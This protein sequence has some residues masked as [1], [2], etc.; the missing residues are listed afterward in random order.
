MQNAIDLR[1]DTVTRPT[2]AM[3]QA[4]IDA[5]V[6]DDVYAEDPSINR[7]QAMTAE[8]SGKEAALFFPSGT[9]SNQASLAAH[10]GRCREVVMPEGAHVYEYEPAAMALVSS[11]IPRFVTA[12]LGIPSAADVEAVL[13]SNIHQAR[14]GLI[15]LENTHNQAGGT[16]IP[17]ENAQ[18]IG[19]VARKH[20]LPYH[21]DGARAWNAMIALEC[22]LEEVCQPFDSVSLCLSKGLAAPVGTV[23]VG[24][25]DFIREAHRYRKSLG[26][27]MRQ[28]GMV[29]AAGIVA[30]EQMIPRLSEDHSNAR[31][32]AGNL[33]DH[34]LLEIDMASVQSNMV[35][36][37]VANPKALAQK[38]SDNG[39]LCNAFVSEAVRFVTHYH[40]TAEMINQASQIILETVET[41]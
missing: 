22:S 41:L 37:K 1:S 4:M 32:L 40:I 8:M 39:V 17:L 13:R 21:L 27:G 2:A 34:P 28:A 36:A 7:L 25:K 16:V 5:P 15:V 20:A 6:G 33:Q 31:L 14:T 26:G 35:Y 24:S 12:P 23:L 30:L 38:L 10:T 11:A 3:R 9:M 29:A 19:A 18:E